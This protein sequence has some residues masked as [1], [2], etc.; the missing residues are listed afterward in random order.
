MVVF[1]LRILCV[2]EVYKEKVVKHTIIFILDQKH[3]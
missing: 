3:C 2:N 1:Y